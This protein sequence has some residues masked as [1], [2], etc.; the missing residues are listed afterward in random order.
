MYVTFCSMNY[1][2][3]TEISTCWRNI[4]SIAEIL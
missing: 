1:F 3:F 4:S 2:Q